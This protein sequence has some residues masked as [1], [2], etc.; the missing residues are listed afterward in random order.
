MHLVLSSDDNQWANTTHTRFAHHLYDSTTSLQAGVTKLRQSLLIQVGLITHFL[1]FAKIRRS[2]WPAPFMI[3]LVVGCTAPREWL[4][5]D[6]TNSE[7][8]DGNTSVAFS[9]Y[10]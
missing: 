7:L 10:V 8:M 6:V 2:Y 5:L 4:T 1:R 3:S 9:M